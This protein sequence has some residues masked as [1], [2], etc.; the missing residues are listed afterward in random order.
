MKIDGRCHC[1]NVAYQAEVDPGHVMIC[2]C[3][4]CQTMASSAFRISVF[5]QEESFHLI[6]DPPK[7]YL[8]VTEAG[9][10]RQQAFCDNC[11]THIYAASVETPGSRILGLRVGAIVQRDQLIPK[12][13][14]WT[15]SAQPW[16]THIDDLEATKTQ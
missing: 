8:K 5:C 1:G 11:G 12:R 10:Q 3:T 16:V 4:D 2:H 6:T 13:Q 14:V 9:H 15:R 7:I